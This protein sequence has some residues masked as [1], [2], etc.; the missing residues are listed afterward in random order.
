M[1]KFFLTTIL[2]LTGLLAI[3]AQPWLYQKNTKKSTKVESTNF[4]QT[5]RAFNN[6]W[7]DREV[8][9]GTGF[10]QY[11]R[12]ENFMEPRVYPTGEFDVKAF[13]EAVQ[14][15]HSQTSIYNH[16]WKFLGPANAPPNINR[17]NQLSGLGRLNCIAF[18]PSDEDIFWVGSPS[19][20]IWKTTDGGETF[21]TTSDDLNALGFSD[22]AVHP[23]DPDIIYAVTGDGDAGDTYS[24][25]IIKSTDGGD[26]WESTAVTNQAADSIVF[27]RLLL[28]PNDPD[29]QIAASNIGI[30]V[31]Q[32][33]WE[34]YIYA[35]DALGNKLNGV[36]KDLEFNPD[37]PNVIYAA[38]YSPKHGS[39]S[40]Y[41]SINGGIN[42]ISSTNGM[43]ILGKAGRIELAVT[44]DN[45]EVIYALVC[46]AI[47][48][49]FQGLYKSIDQGETWTE[50]SSGDDINIL[51]W[52][53][54][55]K[56]SGGQGWYDLALAVSPNND[57]VVYAGGINIWRSI[58]GGSGWAL[59]TQW[60][61]GGLKPYVHAD[62]HMLKYNPLNNKLYSCNDGGVYVSKNGIG[63]TDLSNGLEI[64]QIYRLGISPVDTNL[65]IMGN[66]DNGT[67][68]KDINGWYHILSG[69]GMQ[70]LIDPTDEQTMYAELYYGKLSRTT[71]GG[72][73]FT[74]IMPQESLVGA[75]I[76][77]FIMS[78]NDPNTLLAGYEDVYKTTNQGDNW[79]KLSNNLTGGNTKIK[80][81]ALA[82]SNEDFIYVS[83]GISIWMTNDEGVNWK[84]VNRSWTKY[85]TSITVSQFIPEKIWVTLSGH[86]ENEKVFMSM[87]AGQSWINYSNGL[88]NVPVNCMVYQNNAKNTLYAGTDIG[89][90]T[91][92]STME[93]WEPYSNNLP[94]VVVNDLEINYTNHKLYAGTYGRGVWQVPTI[95]SLGTYPDFYTNITTACYDKE[96]PFYY[97]G[98]GSY[99]SLRWDFGANSQI[100]DDND[101]LPIVVYDSTGYKSIS[102]T[103]YD[104]A[105]SITDLKSEYIKIVESLEPYIVSDVEFTC[106]EPVKFK[107]FGG[108]TYKWTPKEGLNFD[109]TSQ[110]YALPDSTT[111]YY[112]TVSQG[113][114]TGLDSITLNIIDNDTP[115]DATHLSY[116]KNGPFANY[117]ATIDSLNEPVPPLSGCVGQMSWCE[118]EGLNNSVWFSF[119][120]SESNVVS[121]V[122][123]GFD[124]QT[125]VYDAESCLQLNK[126]DATLLAANDDVKSDDPKS[127]IRELT[128][129]SP[130]KKYWLQ[131]DGSFGGVTG[132]FTITLDDK[133]YV[134]IQQQKYQ[135]HD[136]YTIYPNPNKGSFNIS[137]NDYIEHAL[138][139]IFNNTG[140]KI[141]SQKVD[142]V[143]IDEV[144]K[145]DLKYMNTGL[146]LLNLI[147][148]GEQ[149]RSKLI[150]Q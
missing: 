9:K 52:D 119:Y 72:N 36:F 108:D 88:P 62:H 18:H 65:I 16:H 32:D 78:H 1:K 124:A 11:K 97:S 112:L 94:N 148:E 81:M 57:D 130:D 13:W 2:F 50:K 144:I 150:L 140:Q 131:V 59:N 15:A 3:H 98:S 25:G 135:N 17:P 116:V 89:V 8:T 137:M 102:L 12:W 143:A 38:S 83:D 64:L 48:Y 103:L 29:H 14:M 82:P 100:I 35:R 39:S 55:G 110:V 41:K 114:C 30:F 123:Q 113:G 93:A 66:Q 146:Y 70:C 67:M 51:G 87:N 111:T 105:D 127:V 28:N 139:E 71:D 128:G 138:I 44:K 145:I 10:K 75:W 54:N 33:G 23:L 20:G 76:T 34:S 63:W 86:T 40:V 91:R 122:T 46:N 42:F 134:N 69:D 115:C 68:L 133:A 5:Q 27:R 19:G 6:Y 106:T 24:I 136:L 47:D 118:S 125:A 45:S 149:F 43:D 85:V 37:N 49:G 80:S 126:Q 129:L 58:N 22:I 101:T 60:Y 147:R 84:K 142:N 120:G 109:D 79:E 90:Y 132:E 95:D 53:S 107:A 92:N 121:I 77:P 96:I 141:Y 99:D 61:Y 117:C 56:E 7:E 4:Y 74:N 31:T 26:T 104:G 21:S 73:N